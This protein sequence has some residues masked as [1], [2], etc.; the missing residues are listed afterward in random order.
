MATHTT[1]SVFWVT[2][3]NRQD[4]VVLPQPAEDPEAE[5]GWGLLLTHALTI[6]FRCERPQCGYQAFVAAFAALR[7]SAGPLDG[8]ARRLATAAVSAR[9]VHADR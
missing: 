9:T 1:G 3:L 6:A 5:A 4:E 2:V 8:R 7:W